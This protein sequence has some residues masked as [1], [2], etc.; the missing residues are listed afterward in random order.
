MATDARTIISSP[1]GIKLAY[2]IGKYTPYPLGYRIAIFAGDRIASQKSLGMVRAV[3]ANQWIVHGAKP[4]KVSLEKLV[5]ANFRSIACSIFDMYHTLNN[6]TA[7]LRIIEPNPTAI[8]LVQRPEYS[9]RGLI[10]AGV[11]MSNFDMVFHV[12]GLAGVKALAVTL[13]ELDAGYRVQ[14]KMREKQGFGI[15]QASVGAI[16]HAINYLKSGG[17]VI[18]AMDR[19]DNNNKYHPQFFGHPAPLPMHH[20]FMALKAN[21]PVMVVAVF[22]FPDGK[23]HILFSEPIEMEPNPDRSTELLS[24]AERLLHVA[25]GFICQDSSQWAMTFPAWPDAIDQVP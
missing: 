12:G 23:Y 18:T 10:L 7:A 9:S 8:Q 4:D 21:V 22:K 3:R 5:K 6:P 15:V 13:P 17:L 20:V 25:E 16:K 24:N 14:W 1:F 11:H 2:L 19:P